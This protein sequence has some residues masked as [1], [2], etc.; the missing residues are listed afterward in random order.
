MREGG[1]FLS[2][3]LAVMKFGRKNRAMGVRSGRW[4]AYRGLSPGNPRLTVFFALTDLGSRLGT[5]AG[6]TRGG[7]AMSKDKQRREAK[8]PKKSKVVAKPVKP[9]AAGPRMPPQDPAAESK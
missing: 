6:Q 3:R 9:V 2:V 1:S 4:E 7:G 5:V 8:K